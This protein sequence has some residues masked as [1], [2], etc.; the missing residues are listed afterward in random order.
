MGSIEELLNISKVSLE[1]GLMFWSGSLTE[2]GFFVPAVSWVPASSNT[3]DPF[4]VPVRIDNDCLLYDIIADCPLGAS[5][6]IPIVDSLP[7]SKFSNIPEEVSDSTKVTIWEYVVV[8][9]VTELE[10][11]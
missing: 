2:I 7:K 8:P 9:S 6:K 4:K 5:A 10:G 3:I 11:W 1:P